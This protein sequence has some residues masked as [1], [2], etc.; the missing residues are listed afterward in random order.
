[1]RNEAGRE[2]YAWTAMPTK[3]VLESGETLPF[4]SRLASPPG[5]AAT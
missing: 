1:M 3:E 4:R 2:V 5:R